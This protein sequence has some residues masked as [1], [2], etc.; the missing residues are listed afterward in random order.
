[1]LELTE[2]Q[3]R[4]VRTLLARRLPEREV[5]VFGSRATGRAKPHSDLDLVVMGDVPVGDWV[6]AELM[7]DF[8]DSDLPF[9]VDLLA[10]CEAPA[11]LRQTITRDG[12]PL[13]TH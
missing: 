13:I 12:V 2:A 8:D 4:T 11:A 10:W 9:R 1:M 7:A 6:R 3:L 5:R